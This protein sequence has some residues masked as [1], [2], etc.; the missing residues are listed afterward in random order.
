MLQKKY[1]FWGLPE[2]QISEPL[3]DIENM[4]FPSLIKN[5]KSL[6]DLHDLIS[7]RFFFDIR[8]F[9]W[10]SVLLQ[11]LVLMIWARQRNEPII[12]QSEPLLGIL[13]E[14]EEPET[15]KTTNKPICT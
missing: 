4:W 14:C 5:S 1:Y 15:K 12:K 8:T 2:P 6:H 11:Q 9:V 10:C 7:A 13:T 3:G